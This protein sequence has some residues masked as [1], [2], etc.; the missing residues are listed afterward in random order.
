MRGAIII[1]SMYAY[2]SLSLYIYIYMYTYVCIAIIVRIIIIIITVIIVVIITV[3]DIFVHYMLLLLLLLL[4]SLSLLLL[5]LLSRPIGCQAH[6]LTGCLDARP[7]GRL[8]AWL[9]DR[10]RAPRRPRCAWCAQRTGRATPRGRR[11]RAL[12][13]CLHKIIVEMLCF[14]IV[15]CS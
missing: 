1:H 12:S 10:S 8:A 15:N 2:I 3:V 5:S 6:R 4:L 9:H 7:P 13:S 11:T 14:I